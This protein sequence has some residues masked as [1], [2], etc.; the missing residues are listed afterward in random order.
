MWL[1]CCVF[2]RRHYKN[3]D[4]YSCHFVDGALK[5]HPGHVK[6]QAVGHHFP[7]H[8]YTVSYT[9]LLLGRTWHDLRWQAIDMLQLLYV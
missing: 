6:C 3:T 4:P 8:A 2:T 1:R 7:Q 5:Y 9:G